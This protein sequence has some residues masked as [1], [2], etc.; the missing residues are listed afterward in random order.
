MLSS[1]DAIVETEG[2]Y[3]VVDVS[4]AHERV[5]Y[6]R[7]LRSASFAECPAQTLLLPQT[8]A[9]QP[10]EADR[11]RSFLPVFADMGFD[12]ED[13]GG[14]SFLVRSMPD[15]LKDVPAK[16]LLQDT[17]TAIAEAG[18]EKARQHWR[19]ELVAASAARAA[20]RTGKRLDERELV[21]LLLELAAC[22]LPYVSPSGRPTML[23][24]PSREL[25][26]R[27]GRA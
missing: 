9:L 25:D 8:V 11:V 3:A 27:F 20:V 26:R 5:V 7:L 19:E 16:T 4:A 6:E 22:R 21:P 18:R 23:F 17:A 14:D 1:G 13:F 12:V 15:A 24:T 2:G 10:V